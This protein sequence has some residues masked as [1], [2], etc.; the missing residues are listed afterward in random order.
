MIGHGRFNI[1]RATA[2]INFIA[3]IA[4]C[5]AAMQIFAVKI[6][7]NWWLSQV[8]LRCEGYRVI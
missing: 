4:Q 3:A 7:V 5:E 6:A 1:N 8:C 2:E